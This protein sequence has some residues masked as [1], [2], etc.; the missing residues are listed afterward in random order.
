MAAARKKS[1][2]IFRAASQSS[3]AL[4]RLLFE[5]CGGEFDTSAS[6]RSPHAERQWASASAL[7]STHFPCAMVAAIS[8]APARNPLIVLVLISWPSPRQSAPP[9]KRRYYRHQPKTSPVY[10]AEWESICIDR[11]AVPAD[12]TTRSR[13]DRNRGTVG[14]AKENPGC[15]RHAPAGRNGGG[16]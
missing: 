5:S 4:F 3:M 9:T 14:A 1:G 16:H 2:R 10:S 12:R 15:C 8:Q 7:V 6:C 11:S 13:A